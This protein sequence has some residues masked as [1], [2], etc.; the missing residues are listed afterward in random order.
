MNCASGPSQDSGHKF[1]TLTG[2]PSWL[3]QKKGLLNKRPIQDGQLNSACR[4]FVAHILAQK[5]VLKSRPQN[6]LFGVV[7]SRLWGMAEATD[8]TP[9]VVYSFKYM[10]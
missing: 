6:G 10:D 7:K 9:I 4:R 5:T 8:R 3:Y 2:S 1:Q